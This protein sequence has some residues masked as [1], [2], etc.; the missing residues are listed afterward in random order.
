MR[1]GN[2]KFTTKIFLAYGAFVL[3]SALA[4]VFFFLEPEERRLA[5][6]E[7]ETLRAVAEGLAKTVHFASSGPLWPED[8]IP[9]AHALGIRLTLIATDGRVI[10]D[11]HYPAAAMENH[12]DRPEVK[13][14]LS[15]EVS[16]SRR[17]SRT[18][19][20]EFLYL[21]VPLNHRGH[22]VGVLRVAKAQREIA[23]AL[24]RL[25]VAFAGGLGLASLLA[26]GIGFIILRRLIRPLGELEAAAR[27]LG[28]GELGARVR[29]PGRDELGTLA[30]AFN[31]MAEEIQG[32]VANLAAEKGRLA[33]VLSTMADGVLVFDGE[34]R[35]TLANKKAGEFLGLAANAI[36]GRT[37]AELLLPGAAKELIAKAIEEQR[38][39][40]GEFTLDFPARRH[41]YA[42]L[43]PVAEAGTGSPST[44]LVLRDLTAL[45]RL[46][47]VRQ[48]FVANV[49]HELR[50]P[51]AAVKL[52]VETLLR[53]GMDE[54]RRRDFLA[55][56]EAECD[57]LNALVNDLLTLAKLDEGKMP[58][59]VRV[60]SLPALVEEVIDRLFPPGEAPRRPLFY[61][62]PGLP[63]A[64]ADPDHVPQI[65]INLLDNAVRH[66]PAGTAFGVE[67]THDP[68][69]ITVTVWDEGP[70][71]PAAER[72]RIFERF[73][74]LDKARS[75]AAGG[76]GLGLAI[77]KHLVEGYGGR[78]W[79]EDGQGARFRFTLPRA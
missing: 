38:P 51:L 23:R 72:K 65:L 53:D 67:A 50:T 20:T 25:R 1:S 57:R 26:L 14:A 11:S 33:A 22:V 66:T 61:F 44:L 77:V 31:R 19:R 36:E 59:T 24:H 40:E 3:L 68:E 58:A 52:M 16:A 70:G 18:L 63:P 46:E 71:I 4:F 32:L 10:G 9:L 17:F 73:Y 21:A 60:F 13:K 69:W 54:A 2:F 48:D 76:T 7:E 47:R 15:G 45:R 39:V 8:L 6:R 5:R 79:V 64:K 42:V 43:T 30:E 78:V 37:P 41:L 12:R 62:P 74:R 56:I 27:R 34:Q 55:S 35:V 75:R 29:V 49:S 28:R